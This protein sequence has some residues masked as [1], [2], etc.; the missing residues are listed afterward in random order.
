MLT[1]SPGNSRAR[2]P[3][4]TKKKLT[5]LV[6][7]VVLLA[8]SLFQFVK[9]AEKASAMAPTGLKAK[10][11][12]RYVLLEWEPG[13]ITER[14]SYSVFR[15]EQAQGPFKE[16]T[17]NNRDPFFLDQ[18]IEVGKTYYYQVQGFGEFADSNRTPVVSGTGL[19][20]NSTV[21]ENARETGGLSLPAP[22]NGE[23]RKAATFIATPGDGAIE[24]MWDRTFYPEAKLLRAGS[25]DGEFRVIAAG[26]ADARFLDTKVVNGQT[27]FYK[28][29]ASLQQKI[30]ISDIAEAMPREWSQPDA[31]AY[32]KYDQK[33]SG[34]GVFN[35]TGNLQQVEQV[36]ADDLA[37]SYYV[38]FANTGK[39]EERFRVKAKFKPLPGWSLKCYD[40][41]DEESA[42]D[43]TSKICGEGWLVTLEK[44]ELAPSTIMVNLK[45][46]RTADLRAKQEVSFEI[47][48]IVA[49]EKSSQRDAVKLIGSV[50][51][52]ASI[53]WSG[54][55]EKW[56]P[57]TGPK[58]VPIPVI[59]VDTTFG[60]RIVPADKSKG[61]PNDP[62]GHT[63]N[64]KAS[65]GTT[66]EFNG[67]HIWLG[68]TLEKGIYAGTIEVQPKGYGL[69]PIIIRVENE[70]K[71]ELSVNSHHSSLTAGEA[72]EIS[73]FVYDSSGRSVIGKRV[74]FSAVYQNGT[75]AGSF[76][77][78]SN[79]SGIVIIDK[80]GQASLKLLTKQEA[81]TV[82][83]KA[84]FLDTNGKVLKT[85]MARELVLRPRPPAKSPNTK[86]NQRLSR[87]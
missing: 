46:A 49:S 28:V 73:A 61:W 17:Q 45:P 62:F 81:G 64:V 47:A 51:R 54:G 48:P 34:E 23:T 15:A 83:I 79:G 2:D 13:R 57:M 26:L 80:A 40:G 66:Q 85:V 29:V 4:E 76:E 31:T 33:R 12:L 24:L 82:K 70:S 14:V 43:I 6:V 55:G 42:T 50:Q 22:G 71:L 9:R 1:N 39:Q 36:M 60:L 18:T 59:P 19:G 69:K 52:I 7:L 67:E 32:K 63:W 74:R 21:V 68:A 41:T 38:K 65:D 10:S 87:P 53:E 25:K 8:I 58:S 11:G 84:E 56:W 27:Y 77:G 75:P 16:V 72:T 20:S 3:R 86:F 37:G 5:Y 78:G 30:A 35:T 44:N